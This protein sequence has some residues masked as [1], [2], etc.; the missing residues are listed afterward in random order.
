MA[1]LCFGNGVNG[2]SGHGDPDVFYIGFTGQD[3]VADASVNW[4][5]QSAQEFQD[6]LASIGDRLVQTL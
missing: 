3:A 6:S 4:K 2:N 1:T 5:A